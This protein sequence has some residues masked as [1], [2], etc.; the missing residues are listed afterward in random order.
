MRKAGISVGLKEVV[1]HRFASFRQFL[2][3][4]TITYSAPS[5]LLGSKTV[6]AFRCALRVSWV[7]NSNFEFCGRPKC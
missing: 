2:S 7:E 6:R 5:N 3:S 4:G 1:I